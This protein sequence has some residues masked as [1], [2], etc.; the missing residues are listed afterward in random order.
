MTAWQNVI[1]FVY[2]MVA[3]IACSK[4]YHLEMPLLVTSNG[5]VILGIGGC[6]CVHELQG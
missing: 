3:T 1:G 2:L 5:F 4:I 6:C